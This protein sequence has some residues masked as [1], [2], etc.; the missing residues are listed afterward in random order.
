MQPLGGKRGRRTDRTRQRPR[1]DREDDSR[2]GSGIALTLSGGWR[3][4]APSPARGAKGWRLAAGL[5][6]C[7]FVVYGFAAGGYAQQVG[8][9]LTGRFKSLAVQAGF[10]VQQIT[11]EGQKRAGDTAIVKALGIEP[12]TVMLSFDTAAAQDR[13]ERLPWVRRAQVM[14]LLPSRLHVVVEE[15]R[16]FA[17]WQNDGVMHLV[18]RDGVAIAQV[19]RSAYPDLPLVVGTG[20]GANASELFALLEPWQSL[21]GRVSAAVRVA[22]RRWNLKLTNGMEIRLP[23]N[24]AKRAVERI[25][26]LDTRHGILSGD[27]RA[28]DLRIPG[29]VTVRLSEDAAKRRDS[30]FTPARPQRGPGQQT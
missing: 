22:D 23:E 2:S 4:L 15:R 13:L 30:T 9:H 12:G 27:A 21:A 18:D 25:V 11:I 16:P 24:N 8:E 3:R 19:E 29:R 6:V 7:A 1:K 10:S 17:V 28:L 20:A 5:F 14:R 26:E